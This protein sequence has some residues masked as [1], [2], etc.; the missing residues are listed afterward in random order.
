[1]HENKIEFKGPYERALK[2]NDKF[3]RMV[4]FFQTESK[5]KKEHFKFYN[6]FF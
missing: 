4:Q 3:L 5:K 1:M 6:T 2:E